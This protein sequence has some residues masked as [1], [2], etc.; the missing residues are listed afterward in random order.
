MAKKYGAAVHRTKLSPP[1]L[2]NELSSHEEKMFMHQFI[3]RFDAVGSLIKLMDF[4]CAASVTLSTLLRELPESHMVSAEVSCPAEDQDK[5][6]EKLNNHF[7]KQPVDDTDGL[8]FSFDNG[9]VLVIPRKYNSAIRIISHGFTEE[10]A[11][12]L[13]DICIDSITNDGR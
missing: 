13:S 6:L 7:G 3:Y 4:L 2:M 1:K 5:T 12:E 9:W 8:K 10:Y 11:R